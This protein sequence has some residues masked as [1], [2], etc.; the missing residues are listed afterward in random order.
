MIFR[1]IL[2]REG[3]A[4]RDTDRDRSSATMRPK[5]DRSLDL[6]WAQSASFAGIGSPIPYH[7]LGVITVSDWHPNGL[8][9]WLRGIALERGPKATADG[10][11]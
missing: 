5:R 8:R 10:M 2:T 4:T 11:G 1:L 7:L 9:H 3:E 6:G